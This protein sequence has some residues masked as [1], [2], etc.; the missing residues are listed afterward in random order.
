MNNKNTNKMK[1]VVEFKGIINGVE[2]NDVAA[3][4]ARMNELIQAGETD[5]QASSSTSV[6][7]VPVADPVVTTTLDVVD[8]DLSH[9][10]YMDEDDPF[11]LDLLVTDDSVRNKEAYKE[12]QKVLEKCYRYTVES[13]NVDPDTTNDQRRDYYDEVCE[14][15]SEIKDDITNTNNA[16][17]SINEKR[18]TLREEYEREMNRLDGDARILNDALKVGTMFK[19]YYEDIANE[20]I[21]SIKMHETCDCNGDCG[22]NCTCGCHDDVETAC[23][24][25]T[26]PIVEDFN[27]L[28]DRIFNDYGIIRR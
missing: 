26:P 3:Y 14:V 12:A 21:T 18:N 8:E 6:Q 23:K 10:P 4:N 7:H 16:I 27:K 20:T 15:I 2:F 19:A 1:K 9:F 11:Y 17:A 13:L 5:I 22:A 28:I 24:E 25:V